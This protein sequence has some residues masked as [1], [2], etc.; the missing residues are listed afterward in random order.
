MNHY[1]V[2]FGRKEILECNEIQRW[3]LW[4]LVAGGG[5]GDDLWLLVVV[6]DECGGCGGG[7][8]KCERRNER[9]LV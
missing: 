6:A 5:E 8:T 9:S 2:L 3:W 4:P 7:E 1:F